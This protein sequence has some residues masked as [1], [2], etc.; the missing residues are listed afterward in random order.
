MK[1]DLYKFETYYKLANGRLALVQ[2]MFTRQSSDK[3][4]NSEW[5]REERVC[6]CFRPRAATETATAGPDMLANR[7]ADFFEDDHLRDISHIHERPTNMPDFDR[8]YIVNVMK[9]CL[10]PKSERSAQ[11][12]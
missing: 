6:L 11:G 7:L 2:L 10:T 12:I 1:Q 3:K 8:E 9:D 4:G 5:K